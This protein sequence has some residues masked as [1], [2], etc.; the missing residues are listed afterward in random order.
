K[1]SL[2]EE[3]ASLHIERTPPP[4]SGAR[5]PERIDAPGDDRP[6]RPARAVPR[7][8]RGRTLR[9]AAIWLVPLAL[10]GGLVSFGYREYGQ[11]QAKPEVAVELVRAMTTGEAEQLLTAKGYL[12]SRSQ[13]LVGAKVPGRIQRLPIEE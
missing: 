8:G 2:R 10:L 3:L 7:R 9:T 12:K 11:L 4:R 6:V 5:R 1:R 13:A